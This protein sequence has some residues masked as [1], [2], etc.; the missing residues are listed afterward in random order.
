MEEGFRV[1]VEKALNSVRR[2]ISAEPSTGVVLGSGLGSFSARLSGQEIPYAEIE[3]FGATSVAGHRGLLTVSEDVAVLGGRFHYYEG[4]S[5]DDVVLPVFVLHGLG[6]NRLILTNAAGGVREGFHPGQLVLIRDH[7]NLL[8][9]NPL[10]GPNPSGLGPRFP[11][12][13]TV[14]SAAFR[15]LARSASGLDLEEGVYAALQGPCYETPSEIR[16][17]RALGADMVGMSTVPEA[18][19]AAYLGMEVLG[20]SCITNMA[21]GILDEPLDHQEVVEIGRQVEGEF[22]DLLAGVVEKL[23]R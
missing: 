2:S 6:I 20:I 14:Y 1:R 12:M 8:G 3:G 22:C 13:S 15:Q 17:V 10:R 4:R 11:D 5:M 19:C 21:A 18:L 16:M 23:S 9:V 7:L